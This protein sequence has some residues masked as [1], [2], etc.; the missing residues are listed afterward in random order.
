LWK[1]QVQGR[2][3]FPTLTSSNNLLSLNGLHFSE[4]AHLFVDGQR[5]DGTVQIKE[6]SKVTIAL[7]NLPP[8]GMHLLQVQEPEGRMSNDFIF[9]VK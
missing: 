6:G 5:V 3:N 8:A 9:H 1:L 2:Q 7:T 4:Y